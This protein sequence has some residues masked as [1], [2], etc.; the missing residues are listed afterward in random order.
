MAPPELVTEFQAMKPQFVFPLNSYAD[1]ENWAKPIDVIHHAAIA[2]TEAAA[3]LRFS[4]DTYRS[5]RN[6]VLPI[7]RKS[8]LRK[9]ENELQAYTYTP[10][11]TIEPHRSIN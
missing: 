1:I 6:A 5:R 11:L 8:L 3:M 4:Q 7:M 9:I 10:A 2:L